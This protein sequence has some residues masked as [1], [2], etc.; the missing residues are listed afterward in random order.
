[1][2]SNHFTALLKLKNDKFYGHVALN[3]ANN[4]LHLTMPRAAW[5]GAATGSTYRAFVKGGEDS[6]GGARQVSAVVGW[7]ISPQVKIPLK[8]AVH[9]CKTQIKSSILQE[10][11]QMENLG[12]L[13]HY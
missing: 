11:I 4:A 5:S 1:M 13:M 8:L 12:N 2:V 6:N 9:L 7:I 3:R 10:E